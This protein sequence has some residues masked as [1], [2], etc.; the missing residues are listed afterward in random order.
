MSACV[1][2]FWHRFK[3]PI[4]SESEQ[5]KRAEDREWRA[6]NLKVFGLIWLRIDSILPRVFFLSLKLVQP[7]EPNFLQV[8]TVSRK[9][10][11]KKQNPLGSFFYLFVDASTFFYCAKM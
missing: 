2:R 1:C 11:K 3:G 6:K 7:E 4:Q 10:V 8:W 5:K 9:I